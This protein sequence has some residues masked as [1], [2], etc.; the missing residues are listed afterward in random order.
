MIMKRILLLIGGGSGEWV[1]LVLS[2]NLK[3][4]DLPPFCDLQTPLISGGDEL[5]IISLPVLSH[6]L[7]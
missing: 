4:A 6:P 5:V 2:S 1:F 7:I 3:I